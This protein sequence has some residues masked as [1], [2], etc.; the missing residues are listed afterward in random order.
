V[1]HVL[2]VVPNNMNDQ[3]QKATVSRGLVFFSIIAMLI[4]V[5][6]AIPTADLITLILGVFIAILPLIALLLVANQII[7]RRSIILTPLISITIG[8]G[9]G[10]L[11]GFLSVSA[12]HAITY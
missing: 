2:A 8:F 3:S 5:S 9:L 10:I 6:I 7:R 1:V 11:T 12:F 4:G